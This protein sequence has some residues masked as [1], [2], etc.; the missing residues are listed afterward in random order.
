MLRPIAKNCMKRVRFDPGRK[1]WRLLA[2]RHAA[3]YIIIGPKMVYSISNRGM[4][5]MSIVIRT[6][7]GG[8]DAGGG[9]VLTERQCEGCEKF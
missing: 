8:F 4:S 1:D 7:A 9:I 6:S 2:Q 5:N 3:R